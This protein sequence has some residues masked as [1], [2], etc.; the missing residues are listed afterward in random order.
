MIH[1]PHSGSTV[2]KVRLAGYYKREF[3]G[4]VRPGY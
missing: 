4:A 1:S 2:R 3:A